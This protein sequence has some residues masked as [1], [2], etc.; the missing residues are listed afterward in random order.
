M[1]EQIAIDFALLH[2]GK[3]GSFFLLAPN[4][5]WVSDIT[6]IATAR[7]WLY[8]AAVMDLICNR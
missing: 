4:R 1:G 5:C 6:Q 7:G 3:L 8:L 2:T